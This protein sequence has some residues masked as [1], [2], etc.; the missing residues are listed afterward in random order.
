MI[1]LNALIILKKRFIYLMQPNKQ[2][3]TF[4]IF[5]NYKKELMKIKLLYCPI[6]GTSTS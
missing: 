5:L 4:T 6:K 3:P 2:I 1:F